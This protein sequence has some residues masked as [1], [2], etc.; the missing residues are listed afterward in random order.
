MTQPGIEPRSPGPLANTQPTRPMSWYW[1]IGIVVK[2][3]TSSLGDQGSI[4][5]RV[6]QKTQKMLLNASLLDTQHYKVRIKGKVEQSKERNSSLLGVVALI[7]SPLTGK[8]STHEAN[9]PVISY[10]NDGLVVLFYGVPTLFKSFNTELN[11]KQFS[12]A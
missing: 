7:I 2:V 6:I 1:P 3:F 10:N 12:F 5:G 11:F 8:H 4:L 9:G